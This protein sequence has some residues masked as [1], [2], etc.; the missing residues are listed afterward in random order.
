MGK[1][2]PDA[3]PPRDLAKEISQILSQ[4]G[5]LY[6]SEAQYGPLNLGL[7]LNNLNLALEGTPGGTRTSTV[8][9]PV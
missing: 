8:S 3:A 1:D 7:D 2:S 6:N 4:S 5:A 9:N